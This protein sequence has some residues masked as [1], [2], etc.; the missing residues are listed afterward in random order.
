MIAK[1]EKIPSTHN[2]KFV[3][4][5][6][7][8]DF[9]ELTM[10]A[11]YHYSSYHKQKETKG[12]FEMFV[13]GL[14]KNRSYFVVAGIQQVID[15][16]LNLS[17]NRSHIS[18]LQSL[19]VM[20][21]LDQQD[22]FFDYLL[23]FKFTGDIW[24]V[25]EGTILFPN[26]PIIRV[27]GPIIE[28]QLI[29]TY[30]L[31][32][33]NFQSLIATK[34]SRLINA[35]RGKEVIEFGSRRAHGPQA[36]FLAARAAYIGGCAGTSNT[37]AGYKFGI[38]IYGTMAH[39][40]IMSFE[41]EEEAFLQFNSIF[42]QSF[43]LVDT[44]NTINA[45]KEI[46]RLGI[47][48]R[49]IRLDSGDLY[50]ESVT[51]RN[52]L[53]HA[54]VELERLDNDVDTKDHFTNTKIMASGDLNEYIIRDLVNRNAPIDIFAVGTEL[55]TSRDDPA[56]NGVYKLVAVSA[57]GGQERE[58][59]SVGGAKASND[60]IQ[61]NISKKEDYDTCSMCNTHTDKDL[62]LIYKMKTSHGKQTY[63]GPKQI[64]RIL[65]KEKNNGT[66]CIKQDIIS[67]TNESNI[68]EKSSPLLLKYVEGGN[69]IRQLPL[70][71]SI[72]K[73]HLDQLKILPKRFKILDFVPDKFPVTYSK[74]LQTVT[75]S[76]K[77]QY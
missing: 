54:E 33:V 16:V 2:C 15:F 1:N 41:K 38:P 28:S 18:Y 56:M 61:S 14:P 47:K 26:E 17:F 12:I 43:I 29:E 22:G 32:M 13:R 60:E 64:Y 75:N 55:S 66:T 49:G 8:L 71:A 77:V 37:L 58:K 42:P 70:I 51:A 68:S 19:P 45:V 52:L 74:T 25:P 6:F 48:P 57:G 39:S 9:Y 35:A 21:N 73:Y 20:K 36:A 30:V 67:L 10:A 40:F 72:Q 50:S 44:Y 24:A 59:N 4:E 27:Q 23:K 31:C 76:L 3:D 63:P 7:I 46:I 11:A 34:A 5:A 62:R 69:L 53:D 65:K